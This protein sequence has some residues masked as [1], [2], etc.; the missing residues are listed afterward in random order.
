MHEDGLPG[1]SV[2]AVAQTPDGYLWVSTFA[3]LARFDGV[4]FRVFPLRGLQ[5]LEDES[6]V[7]LS[8]D[9]SG[10][11]WVGTLGGHLGQFREGK[12]TWFQMP[13]GQTPSRHTQNLAQAADG[14]IWA[15]NHEGGL[16]RSS[17]GGFEPWPTDPKDRPAGLQA[18]TRDAAGGIWLA[19]DGALFKLV[20]GIPRAA[21]DTARE[22]GFKPEGLAAAREG[23]CWVAANGRVRRFV[24]G[25]WAET[26]AAVE[27]KHS[28]WGMLEDSEG[29]VWL[30]TYGGG[31]AA[32]GRD[33]SVTW[34]TRSQGLPSDM[35]RCLFEDREGN[36][37]AGFEGKGLARIK[38]ASFASYGRTEGLSSE[39]I[40]CAGEGADGEI[41]LGTNG[42]G[43]KRLQKGRILHYGCDQ[44]L[45]EYVW[46]VHTDRAGNVW[47]GT[48]GG[49]ACGGGLFRLV[50][51]RFVNVGAEL[52]FSQVVLALH[53][54]KHGS[55]WVGQQISPDRLLGVVTNGRKLSLTVPGERP[56]LDVRAIAET[57]DG[58]LYFGT[59]EDGL[60]RWDGTSFR[61]FGAADGLP[62]GAITTILVDNAGA[63]WL[64]VAGSGLVLHLGERFAP[65]T[66]ADGLPSKMLT[67]IT[68]D[69]LG[70]L[71]CGSRDGVFRVKL[72]DLHRFFHKQQPRV[73]CKLFTKADGL[74]NIECSGQGCRAQDGRIWFPTTD[75]V[76]IIDPRQVGSKPHPPTVLVEEVRWNDRPVLDALT[77][78]QRVPL[79][80]GPGRGQLELRYTALNFT[81][82]QAVR[83]RHRLQG[84]ETDWVDAGSRRFAAYAYLPPGQYKFRVSACNEDGVWN[85]TGAS[86]AFS[87]LPRFWQT[88]WFGGGMILL[89]LCGVLAGARLATARRLARELAAIEQLRALEQERRRIA[90]DLHDDLG[91]G[92]TEIMLMGEAAGREAT[93]LAE[94]KQRTS[95]ITLKIRQIVGAMD[96]IVWTVNPEN[97]SLPNLADYVSKFAQEYT[98]LTQVRCRL[99]VMT[100][101]PESP[102]TAQARHNLLLAVKEALHNVVKHSG[103]TEVSL[104]I[105]CLGSELGLAI[106][107]NGK[108]FNSTTAA[109]GDGLRNMRQRLEAIGGR[110]EIA[111]HPGQGTS[112]HFYLPLSKPARE[113]RRD[114]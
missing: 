3:A 2:T 23:G 102:V 17:G 103:A 33:G 34:L 20:G 59:T 114:T 16:S 12:F 71:W 36:L 83:F 113:P 66:M 56:R 1:S 45:A 80:L 69:R 57:P 55:L 99:D 79:R 48:W 18:L 70:Y 40:L 47:A 91:S 8:T 106:E 25:H 62:T 86:L 65:A 32:L 22:A 64:G 37:W 52:G 24:D 84:I 28:I 75:G 58:A 81:A 67:Q 98:Q 90:R 111:A 38:R 9:R 110:T 21:W 53:E 39:V 42:D 88:A 105:H 50:G 6:V 11:L 72:D 96:Q 19:G 26:R 112:V 108:G 7:H 35:A 100:G 74:P 63:L 97:D 14:A 43:L 13:S 44:G 49:G 92:L 95:Q 87:I 29:T 94:A 51:D 101:L 77:D 41:W 54:D 68:D 15:L 93:S 5:E 85:E 104:R 61:Q 73:A 107:D 10:N 4:Q 60:L 89:L 27:W 78:A 109:C 30:G 82:P 76:A 46:A 31:L